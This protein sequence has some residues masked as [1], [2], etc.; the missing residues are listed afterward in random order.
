M[1][2]MKLL[3]PFIVLFATAFACTENETQKEYK[4]KESILSEKVTMAPGEW[5]TF[6]FKVT[7]KGS[8]VNGSF[9]TG[10]DKSYPVM[11]YVTDPASAVTLKEKNTGSYNYR[12]VNPRGTIYS[13]SVLKELD[14]G[15]YVFLF[16]NESDQESKTIT[17]RMSLER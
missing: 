16:H 11:F 2:T 13:G 14:P 10:T 15:D 9:D 12:S 8:R 6:P 7:E 4:V 17:I 3:L 5:S 1:K